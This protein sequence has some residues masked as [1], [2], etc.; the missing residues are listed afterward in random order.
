MWDQLC[1]FACSTLL[2]A[3][4]GLE[5]LLVIVEQRYGIMK[6]P[7]FTIAAIPAFEFILHTTFSQS[8]RGDV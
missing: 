6:L 1:I 3:I 8:R 2:I 7:W 5:S 4:L